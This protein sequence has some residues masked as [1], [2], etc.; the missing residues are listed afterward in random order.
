MHSFS[1][2]LP[3]SIHTHTHTHTRTCV[4]KRPK[5]HPTY[6]YSDTHIQWDE[7]VVKGADPAVAVPAELP[8]EAEAGPVQ[9]REKVVTE[10]REKLDTEQK[11]IE[12]LAKTNGVTVEE[13]KKLSKPSLPPMPRRRSS[14]PGAQKKVSVPA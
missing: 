9:K 13:M 11:R 2:T 1:N 5:E 3:T 14:L 10:K 12:G 8:S 6:I 7:K 4:P